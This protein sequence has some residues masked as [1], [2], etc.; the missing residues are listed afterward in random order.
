MNN[1]PIHARELHYFTSLV[2]NGQKR[3]IKCSI[4][5]KV[6]SR[7]DS[8]KRHMRCHTGHLFECHICGLKYNSKY[9]LR[10]HKETKHAIG[11]SSDKSIEN[12]QWIWWDWSIDQWV[13]AECVVSAFTKKFGWWHVAG[14]LLN[15]SAWSSCACEVSAAVAVQD[16]FRL[17]SLCGLW[18]VLVFRM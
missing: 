9:M 2:A 8:Y 6:L 4:C 1:L 13:W 12:G 10:L 3:T 18:L 14:F 16:L 5:D 7:L 11:T 15:T 17:S